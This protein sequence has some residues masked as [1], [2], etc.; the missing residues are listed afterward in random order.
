MEHPL[1]QAPLLLGT[2]PGQPKGPKTDFNSSEVWPLPKEEARQLEEF[3]KA[4]H[5]RRQE[6]LTVFTGSPEFKRL[7]P[8]D[9]PLAQNPSDLPL[10]P[11]HTLRA[12]QGSTRSNLLGRQVAVE[13]RR[14]AQG[15][16]TGAEGLQTSGLS[17]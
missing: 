8:L 2:G 5:S 9:C 14:V 1:S 6:N 4:G 7:R 15:T 3:W 13:A 17:T 11:E 16:D 12:V 10:V